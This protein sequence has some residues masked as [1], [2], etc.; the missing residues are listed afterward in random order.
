MT[1]VSHGTLSFNANGTFTYTPA[2]VTINV[3]PKKNG[4]DDDRGRR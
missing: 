3:V 2:P 1:G 4:R